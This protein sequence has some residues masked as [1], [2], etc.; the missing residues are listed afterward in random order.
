MKQ[1][2]TFP[3][4][5]EK[6]MKTDAHAQPERSSSPTTTINIRRK[7][8]KIGSYEKQPQQQEKKTERRKGS[9]H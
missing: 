2:G 9:T 5:M 8:V 3:E 6:T 4:M 1:N 7:E